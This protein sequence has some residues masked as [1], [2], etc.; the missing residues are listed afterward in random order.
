MKGIVK[1]IKI[2]G[3]K[4]VK[5]GKALKLKATVKATKG[6]N[7]KIQWISSNPKF[8]TVSG[9]GKVKTLAAGKGKKVKITAQ[10][11]DGNGKKK[12]IMIRIK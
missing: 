12:A 7:K 9:S 11:T 8:A 10:A 6:A 4:K 2:T 1:K 3:K 5:A